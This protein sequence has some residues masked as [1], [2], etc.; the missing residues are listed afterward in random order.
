MSYHLMWNAENFLRIFIKTSMKLTEKGKILDKSTKVRKQAL[1]SFLTENLL[2]S[3]I[4]SYDKLLLC[5]GM[6]VNN[7][8]EAM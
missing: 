3:Y 2:K 6:K 8:D 4:I 7:T 5:L 1:E